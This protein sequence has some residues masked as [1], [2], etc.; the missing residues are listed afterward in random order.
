LTHIGNGEYSPAVVVFY[1]QI[2]NYIDRWIIFILTHDNWICLNL[3]R[4]SLFIVEFDSIA[5]LAH[6]SILDENE[7]S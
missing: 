1:K 4:I 2:K 6:W 7:R 3:K 5:Q